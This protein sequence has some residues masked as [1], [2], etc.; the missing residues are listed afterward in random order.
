MIT[1]KKISWIDISKG[2]AMLLVIL[3][4]TGVPVKINNY[5]YSFHMPLFFFLSGYLFKINK[6]HSFIKFLIAKIKSLVVP[7]FAFAIFD[8]IINIFTN[9]Y[10]APANFF[11]A[12]KLI[13]YGNINYMPTALWFLPCLFVVEIAFY[14]IS[15]FIKKPQLIILILIIFSIVGYRSQYDTTRLYWGADIALTGIVFYGAGFLIKCSNISVDKLKHLSK[16]D[17]VMAFFIISLVASHKLVPRVDML[18]NAYR[19]YYYFY[20]AAFAGITTVCLASQIMQKSFVLSYIGRNTLIIL[21][22]QIQ[23]IQCLSKLLVFFHN[24]QLPPLVHTGIFTII[25]LITLIPAIYVITNFLPFMLGRKYKIKLNT[26]N[27]DL[28]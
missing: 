8:Y 10:H 9:N 24:E 14:L 27:K 17:I 18:G 15:K 4:H 1:D 2:I 28:L 13:S 7:Y 11:N 25:T 20:C 23:V 16:T 3:G 12:L 22:L 6:Y 26:L 19:N 5:I 21:A